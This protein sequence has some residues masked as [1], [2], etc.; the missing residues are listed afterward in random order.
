MP[1]AE[2]L[3][4]ADKAEPRVEKPAGPRA[5]SPSQIVEQ[6]CGSP[7]TGPFRLHC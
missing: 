2:M 4:V 7:L 5:L 3:K 6:A 1:T